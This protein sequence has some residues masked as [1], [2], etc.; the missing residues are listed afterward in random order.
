MA[1][2]GRPNMTSVPS[3]SRLLMSAWAPVICI[4]GDPF[5]GRGRFFWA[6]KNPPLWRRVGE[7][8]EPGGGSVR[9]GTTRMRAAGNTA[10]SLRRR[11]AAAATRPVEMSEGPFPDPGARVGPRRGR[12]GAERA[13]HHRDAVRDQH[14]AGRR[15]RP[16]PG[17]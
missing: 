16:T 2:P 9:Y 12:G 14:G 10:L 11:A 3:I 13:Q 15:A 7:R 4:V 6:L 5:V 17:D 1:P 8:S